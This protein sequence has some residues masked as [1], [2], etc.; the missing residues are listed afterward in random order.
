VTSEKIAT[1]FGGTGFVGRYII[2][3]LAK[4]GYRVKVATRVPERAYFLRPYGHVGQIV[5]FACNYRDPLSIASVVR[6]S[7]VVINC[8]GILYEKHRGDFQRV[9]ANLPGLI[10]QACSSVGVKRLVHISALGVDQGLSRYAKTKREGE[11]AL[12][13][14]FPTAT[15][16]RPSVIFGP[17]DNFFNMFAAMAQFLPALPL[18]GGGK[19]R[20]QPVYVEDVAAAA[21]TAALQ[22]GIGENTPQGK[23]YELGGPERFTLRDLYMLVFAQT[24]H[25]RTL[26][27]LP[28]GI[29]KILAAFL[30]LIPPHPLLTPDQVVSLKTDNVISSHALGLED[31][32]IR[33][34]GLEQIVPSYMERFRSGGRFSDIKAA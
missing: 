11:A 1:V 18:I 26:I 12:R 32:G 6:G 9:H 5:P 31:L 19:T 29:A 10:A 21:V 7:D 8:V 34:T 27:S 15:I 23:I 28:F 13:K 20:F 24:G 4:A 25:S 30:Q 3:D 14:S 33:P 17:E 16:L 2:R 22:P